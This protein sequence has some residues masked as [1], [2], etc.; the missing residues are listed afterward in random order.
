LQPIILASLASLQLAPPAFE[1]ELAEC[2]ATFFT[3]AAP[4]INISPFIM[5]TFMVIAEI[6]SRV[7]N[8]C[9]SRAKVQS[10]CSWFP[11]YDSVSTFEEAMFIPSCAGASLPCQ[12]AKVAKLST[13]TAAAIAL[14]FDITVAYD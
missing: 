13:T 9:V 1:N 5:V 10:V 12:S 14:V 4:H 11:G 7:C 3:T 6:L 8:Q 2:L